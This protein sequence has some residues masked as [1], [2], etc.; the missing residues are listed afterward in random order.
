MSR[1]D[2]LEVEKHDSSEDDEMECSDSS[3]SRKLTIPP[4]NSS[5]LHRIP[6]DWSVHPDMGRQLSGD[7]G[8]VTFQMGSIGYEISRVSYNNIRP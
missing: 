6:H 2:S 1:A 7:V 3:S 4:R 8:D 5:E